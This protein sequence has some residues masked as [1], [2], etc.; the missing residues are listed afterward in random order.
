[1]KYVVRHRLTGM[2]LW[3]PAR[4]RHR[5]GHKWVTELNDARVWDRNCDA[6]QSLKHNMDK[7]DA[8]VMEVML[9]PIRVLE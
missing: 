2:F 4:F 7:E 1:M 5:N 9:V 3:K 6:W 8:Q